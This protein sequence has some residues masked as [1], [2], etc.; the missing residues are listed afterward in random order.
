MPVL[1]TE[2]FSSYGPFGGAF[3]SDTLLNRNG[4]ESVTP[5]VDG[6]GLNTKAY[7]QCI[8]GADLF[9]RVGDWLE[10]LSHCLTIRHQL[11]LC[12]ALPY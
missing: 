3:N 7:S 2:V 4:A 12:K 8:H 1:W 11:T 9:G 5:L 6:W 10:R